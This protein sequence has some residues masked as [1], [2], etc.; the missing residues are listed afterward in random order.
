MG[1]KE[2]S[3]GGWMVVRRH[4]R[5]NKSST[6]THSAATYRMMPLNGSCRGLVSIQ[7]MSTAATRGVTRVTC[8]QEGKECMWRGMDGMQRNHT[9]KTTYPSSDEIT[10]SW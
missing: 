3:V 7:R 9:P 10:S 4:A 1:G 2:K 8:D 5:N 6:T